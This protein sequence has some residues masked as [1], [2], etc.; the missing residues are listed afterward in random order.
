MKRTRKTVK[1]VVKELPK[2]TEEESRVLVVSDSSNLS[3]KEIKDETKEFNR[4]LKTYETEYLKVCNSKF[5][6]AFIILKFYDYKLY[7]TGEY[8]NIYD[9]CADKFMMS[10]TSVNEVLN[11]ARRYGKYD[12]DENGKFIPY[13]ELDPI[14]S[15]FNFSQLYVLRK[16]TDDTIF[17]EFTPAMSVRDIKMVLENKKKS[18][19]SSSDL[20]PSVGI[21]DLQPDKKESDGDNTGNTG[22]ND[23]TP[24]NPP[25]KEFLINLDEL[26]DKPLKLDFSK[27]GYILS[28]DNENNLVIK[29]A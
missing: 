25:E 23:K 13:Y 17:S 29:I 5:K 8:A 19:L 26:M 2:L 7:K 21:N 28:L 22:E 1:N 3:L 20:T 11:M 12:K 18:L 6:T 16:L 27:T 14:Y 9:F 24:M 10:K 4:L 15:G